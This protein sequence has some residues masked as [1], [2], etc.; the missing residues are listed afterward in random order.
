MSEV[1]QGDRSQ[2]DDFD[3]SVEPAAAGQVDVVETIDDSVLS[4]ML[5]ARCN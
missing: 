3:F 5:A 1:E 4:G 2:S